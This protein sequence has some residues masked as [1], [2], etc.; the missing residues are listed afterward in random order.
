MWV[1]PLDLT[2][3]S[4]DCVLRRANL[5]FVQCYKGE[6]A[7]EYMS[8]LIEVVYY[9]NVLSKRFYQVDT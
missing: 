8:S 3:M 6:R 7:N 9:F 1:W 5:A 2:Q 4:D